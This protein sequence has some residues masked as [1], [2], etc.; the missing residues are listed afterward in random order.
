MIPYNSPALALKPPPLHSEDIVLD[1]FVLDS[2]AAYA[3]QKRASS[4]PD[5][6]AADTEYELLFNYFLKRLQDSKRYR[7]YLRRRE[8]AAQN[9][10]DAVQKLLDSDF[11]DEQFRVV[12]IVALTRLVATSELYPRRLVL[13]GVTR[14]EGPLIRGKFGFI[15]KGIYNGKVAL[16]REIVPWAQ[17]RHPNVL[18]FHGLCRLPNRGLGFVSA[19]LEHGNIIEF[20]KKNPDADRIAMILGIALGMAFLHGVGLV[21]GGIKG[22]NVLVTDTMPPQACLAD[23]GF[24]NITDV[25]AIKPVNFSSIAQEGSEKQFF[26]PELLGP[27]IPRRRNEAID[28]YAFAMTAY[29]ILTGHVPFPGKS[30]YYVMRLIL[31]GERPAQLTGE[32]YQDRGLNGGIWRILDDCWKQDPGMRP[33]AHNVVQRLS[34]E[35]E[36]RIF[37]R[38]EREE[39]ERLGRALAKTLEEVTALLSQIFNNIKNYR[40]ML[41]SSSDNAQ[42]LLDS[43]QLLLDTDNYQDRVQLIAAMRRLSERTKLYPLRFLLHGSV[44]L[45]ED[46]PIA[47]GNYADIYKV[48]FQ[49]EATCFKVIRVYQRSLVEHMAKVYAREVIVWGQ[50]SHPNILPFYG[51]S[52]FRSRISFVSPWAENGHLSDYLARNPDADRILLCWDTAAGIDYLHKNDIVHGDLK[53]VNV[54]VEGSGRACLGDFGLSSVTDPDIIHWTSQSSMASHGGTARWQAP[55]LHE[56]EDKAD[57]IHNSKKSDVFA[58]ANLCYEVCQW[59]HYCDNSLGLTLFHQIFTG[60]LPYFEAIRESTVIMTILRGGT[61]TRPQNGDPSWV[62]RGLNDRI[63]DLLKDCWKFEPSDRPD[64]GS[65]ISRLRIDK[66]QDSRPSPEWERRASTRFRNAQ[67]T[68]LCENMLPSLENLNRILSCITKEANETKDAA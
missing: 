47:S 1:K 13:E 14:Q 58:W 42:T 43:F 5:S 23:Y 64:M 60:R 37:K 11:V 35:N 16:V 21:H 68:K 51:L 3:Y 49:D 30:D 61:P 34:K 4:S 2:A 48:T 31:R 54:L 62:E 63:W 7:R 28:I 19:Y 26:A 33:N 53:G 8:E 59:M 41:S 44:P 29:Q 18:L 55:E 9:S 6:E 27:V 15:G 20:L 38:A 22:R 32:L 66:P 56:T 50:L 25:H 45:V 24:T 57:S 46:D 12:L 17:L 10:I 52:K 67:D 36:E 39:K 40:C 65:V